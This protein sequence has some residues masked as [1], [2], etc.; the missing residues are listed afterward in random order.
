MLSQGAKV[1]KIRNQKMIQ[2]TKSEKDVSHF[3]V[4]RHL[5]LAVEKGYWKRSL[6]PDIF[7][8]KL[9]ELLSY[10]STKD[11]SNSPIIE[12]T[13]EAETIESYIEPILNIYN[14][15]MNTN[16]VNLSKPQLTA[17]VNHFN[18]KYLKSDNVG[19]LINKIRGHFNLNIIDDIK[20]IKKIQSFESNKDYQKYAIDIR[21]K[22]SLYKPGLI[23]LYNL[24]RKEVPDDET[25]KTKKN[26]DSIEI[27][28]KTYAVDKNK[29]WTTLPLC[30][31]RALR[32]RAN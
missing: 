2:Y 21:I 22:N 1:V 16:V 25:I 15:L 30:Q 26:D 13:T 7:N 9:A 12:L 29:G 10:I 31:Y 19:T 23:K 4:V 20:S 6:F 18:I 17:V 11:T 8:N 24:L 28:E 5:Y 3:I 32:A 14:D 27:T